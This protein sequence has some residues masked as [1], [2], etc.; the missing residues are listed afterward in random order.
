MRVVQGSRQRPTS[1]LSTAATAC[2]GQHN[3]QEQKQGEREEEAPEAGLVVQKHGG[4]LE[5][6][7]CSCP[8]PSEAAHVLCSQRA[9]KDHAR[10]Q[11]I[12]VGDVVTFLPL[13]LQPD[14]CG[15]GRRV[16]VVV[17]CAPRR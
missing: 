7:P 14:E 13:P 3:A 8:G 2:R 11:Q 5:V 10:N 4:R 17:G 12:V 16:G 1:S 15:A 9:S 6:L